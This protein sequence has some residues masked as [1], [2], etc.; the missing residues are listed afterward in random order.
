MI[1]L[2]HT[3]RN[4]NNPSMTVGYCQGTSMSSDIEDFTTSKGTLSVLNNGLLRV[5][6]TTSNKVGDSYSEWGIQ[7][8]DGSVKVLSSNDGTGSAS[9]LLFNWDR[10]VTYFSQVNKKSS[11]FSYS[12][13]DDLTGEKEI[14]IPLIYYSEDDVVPTTSSGRYTGSGGYA[15]TL[16]LKILADG[17]TTETLYV[18]ATKEEDSAKA[19]VSRDDE[20][21]DSGCG[22]ILT[23]YYT[24]NIDTFNQN[25][26]VNYGEIFDW[27][28]VT[29]T[30]ETP[31]E[32]SSGSVIC[33]IQVF[34]IYRA[35]WTYQI[36]ENI[37]ELNTG[38]SYTRGDSRLSAS[39]G[40]GSI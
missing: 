27:K 18:A 8:S 28:D 16:Y 24:N 9:A 26:V 21:C 29:I 10:H 25:N 35:M 1:K 5:S 33:Y 23:I 2:Y 14:Y 36:L 11:G 38:V 39:S 17:D 6:V 34:A 19:E 22:K 13:Y 37:K 20:A 30:R 31:P 3:L 4:T 32:L 12:F 7:A 15:A 40:M